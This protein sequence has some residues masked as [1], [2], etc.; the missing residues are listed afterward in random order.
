MTGHEHEAEEIVADVVVEG[1]HVSFCHLLCHVLL[2]AELLVL[3]LEE[4]A[5]AQQVDGAA[6]A[7][8]HQPGTRVVRDA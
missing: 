6:L 1:V 3:P 2:V 8:D 7:D 4:G 5:P